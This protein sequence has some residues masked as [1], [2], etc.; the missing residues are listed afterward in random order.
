MAYAV[1]QRSHEIDIRRALGARRHNVL[2][3]MVRHGMALT[4]QYKV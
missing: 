4:A 3:M 2:G 1:V